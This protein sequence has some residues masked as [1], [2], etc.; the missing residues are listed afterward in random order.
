MNVILSLMLA[1]IPAASQFRQ[2]PAFMDQK[3]ENSSVSIKDLRSA[4]TVVVLDNKSLSLSAYLWR[5]FNPMQGANGSPLMV[6]F[7]L[8]GADKKPIPSGVRMDRAWVLLGDEIWEASDLRG[9]IP[10]QVPAKDS[11][12]NCSALPV[13]GTTVRDGPKWGPGVSVDVVVLLTDSEGK[14]YFLQA[15]KRYIT[16]TD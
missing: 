14:H 8:A 13:C 1:L 11:W 10:A 3:Q 5:D 4:P 9:R 2:S 15:P 12:I 16:R 6:T 7:K